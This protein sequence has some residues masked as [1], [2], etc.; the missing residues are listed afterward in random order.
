[1]A[2]D[3][4]ARLRALAADRTQPAIARA[5]AVAEWSVLPDADALAALTAGLSDSSALVRFGALQSVERF[6][7]AS[8]LRLA[9]PL[10]SDSRRA[11]RIEAARILADVPTQQLSQEQQG[12]FERAAAEFIETQRYNADRAEAR[13]S[14]GTFLA[15]RGGAARA[16]GELQSATRLEP[17][18][19]PAYV[20]L[21]DVYRAQG[22]DADGE[23]VLR[24]GLAGAP[25]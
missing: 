6:P 23:R 25:R 20:N 13:V 14:L 3:A 4:Q 2:V 8:R 18:S 22:R 17:S 15:Q 7:L 1:G 16:E 9:Q 24:D 11:I 12:A 21:A 19:I 5:S 10:L